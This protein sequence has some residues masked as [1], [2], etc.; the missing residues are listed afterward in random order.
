MGTQISHKQIWLCPLG[1]HH[2]GAVH[3]TLQSAGAVHNVQCTVLVQHRTKEK[4]EHVRAKKSILHDS[5]TCH[6]V[7]NIQFF[8]PPPHVIQYQIFNSSP[9]HA[10]LHIPRT[11]QAKCSH[12]DTRTE[13]HPANSNAKPFP[14]IKNVKYN[15]ASRAEVPTD[16]PALCPTTGPDV[17]RTG[18][19]A[20]P[21]GGGGVVGV[22]YPNPTYKSIMKACH[23]PHYMSSDHPKICSR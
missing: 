12:P 10:R 22:P 18:V 3:S 11:H 1:S 5:S 9:Y 19:P 17:S 16:P 20:D 4:K 21:E 23:A 2:P 13:E 8:T 7:S 14:K 6:P 15:S